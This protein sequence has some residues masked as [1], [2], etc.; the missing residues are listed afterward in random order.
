MI[1]QASI[2]RIGR[3]EINH[4]AS[5]PGMMVVLLIIVCSHFFFF[6]NLFLGHPILI[7]SLGFVFNL[8]FSR[9]GYCMVNWTRINNQ[10]IRMENPQP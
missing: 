4:M 7:I 10:L 9:L 3:F 1:I 2:T 8:H 5:L 6:F